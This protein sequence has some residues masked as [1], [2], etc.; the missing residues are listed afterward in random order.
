MPAYNFQPQ[1]VPMILDGSKRQTIRRRRKHPT[2]A[3]DIL[4]LYTG[5]RTKKCELIAT[6]LC[7]AI[8]PVQINPAWV[9]MKLDGRVLS[10]TEEIAF[11]RLDGF[12]NAYEF[13]AFF[14]RY[15]EE[16]LKN[17]LEVIY[18]RTP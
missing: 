4:Q 13:Y 8:K 18:W 14:E 1:F 2:K 3:G 11:A 15:S 7:T 5:Q 12:R 6:R 10:S 16:I 17:E 9:I